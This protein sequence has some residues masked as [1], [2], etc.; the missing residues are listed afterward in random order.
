MSI[1][2]PRQTEKTDIGTPTATEAAQAVFPD[3]KN[4]EGFTK[5]HKIIG[6][7]LALGG[8]A[9]G[10]VAANH[11][12]SN[13]ETPAS[14][15]QENPG[16]DILPTH[17]ASEP[18]PSVS[19]SN[20]TP[21]ETATPTTIPVP[22]NREGGGSATYKFFSE[23][24]ASFQTF[25]ELSGSITIPVSENENSIEAQTTYYKHMEK[26]ANYFPSET[27]VRNNLNIPT[28]QLT[29]DDYI[30]ACKLYH[31]AYDNLYEKPAGS[32]YSF[33]N[34]LA[35]NVAY[36][37]LETLNNGEAAPYN[38]TIDFAKTAPQFTVGDN[39]RDNTVDDTNPMSGTYDLTFT[40]FGPNKT[41]GKNPTWL[42][43]GNVQVTKA[44]AAK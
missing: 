10:A 17:V 7:L 6:T 42:V 22:E 19:P 8:L 41:T 33:M 32:L 20:I 21:L 28:G 38:V 5:K 34:E 18:L 4:R 2:S 14:K 13:V 15:D 35:V 12:S 31:N 27:E 16:G 44:E 36:A 1:E 23:D 43:D 11:F 30:D 3:S 39:A 24:G 25:E 9:G 37:K 29:V 40:G 26:M